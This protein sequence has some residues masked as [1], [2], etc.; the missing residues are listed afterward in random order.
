MRSAIGL[1]LAGP[2]RP[3]GNMAGVVQ[4]WPPSEEVRYIPVQV[5]TE[6]PIL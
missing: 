6:S 2:I 1:F 4:V 5:G 3:A